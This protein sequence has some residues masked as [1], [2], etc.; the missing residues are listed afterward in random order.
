MSKYLPR[1][2]FL[3]GAGVCLGLPL[4]EAMVPTNALAQQNTKALRFAVM[5]FSNGTYGG[6][7]FGGHEMSAWNPANA[8]ALPATLPVAL[9]PLEAKNR[10]D[11]SIYSGLSNYEVNTKRNGHCT[12]MSSFLTGAEFANGGVGE[13]NVA[14][15]MDQEIAEYLATQKG[16]QARMKSLVMSSSRG[17]NKFVENSNPVYENH[18]S[19]WNKREVFPWVNPK[20]LFDNLVSGKA[21]PTQ[22]RNVAASV[23]DF[24]KEDSKALKKK[25][26][27][28]DQLR[29][30]QYLA[31]LRE[32]ELRVSGTTTGGTC[33]ASAAG[34]INNEPNINTSQHADYPVRMRNLID[35]MVMAFRCDLTRVATLMLDTESFGR[36]FSVV[37]EI[38][39]YL[40]QGYPVAQ[41]SHV[42]S[43]HHD[44]SMPKIASIIAINRYQVSLFRQLLDKLKATKELDG[45]LFANSMILYGCS[46]GDGQ[47]HDRRNLPILIG[48]KGG[49]LVTGQH[50]NCKG[51]QLR[52]LH[53]ALMQKFMPISSWR[54]INTPVK[55]G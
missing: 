31:E 35:I 42:G 55:L 12:A 26:G 23:L 21:L 28:E 36:Q 3:R 30:D 46:M 49:G 44:D 15:S 24:V 40:F 22:E 4:L 20:A 53:L 41:N 54:G 10:G 48:G 2:T 14:N 18:L 50:F 19:F 13:V 17:Q 51:Q 9:T 27:K 29:M 5:Y 6:K 52:G 32:I 39:Q 7:M 33:E 16:Y 47:R 37:P 8:G 34:L 43:A 25:L 38:N 11:F 45:T 1:R